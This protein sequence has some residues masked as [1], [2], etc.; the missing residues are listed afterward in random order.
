M[1]TTFLPYSH[2]VCGIGNVLHEKRSPKRTC[3]RRSSEHSTYG[4]APHWSK[5]SSPLYKSPEIIQC[6]QLVSS[7]SFPQNRWFILSG[8]SLDS[9]AC[10]DVYSL[11]SI[12]KHLV[13]HAILLPIP[14]SFPLKK[15]QTLENTEHDA[16]LL[17]P[18]HHHHIHT[19]IQL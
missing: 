4:D 3:H 14:Q 2:R 12:P 1:K 16:V 6:P 13:I 5:C 15:P 18:V 17:W 11:L 10:Q 8:C 7:S 9:D 19:N